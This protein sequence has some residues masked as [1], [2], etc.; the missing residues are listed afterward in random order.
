MQ[1]TTTD[2]NFSGKEIVFFLFLYF[3]LLIS[4]FLGE[5]STGGA[6]LD[7]INQKK[8]STAFVDDFESTLLNYGNF[9]TRHSPIFIIFLSIFEKFRLSDEFIRIIHLHMCL[10]FPL[11][12]YQTLKIKFPNLNYKIFIFLTGLIFLSPTFRTLAIWPDSRML[13]L[14]FFIISVFFFL[15]FHEDKKFL[16]VI[17]NIFFYTISS[18][19][20]PNFSVFS[21]FFFVGYFKMFGFLSLKLFIIILLNFLLSFPAIYYIFI[22]KVDF[23]NQGAAIG[24]DPDSNFIFTNIFNS[25]LLTFSILFFYFIP[26]FITKII[27]I[28]NILKI[29]NLISSLIIFLICFFYFDYDYNIS[30]GGIFFK[31]SNFIFNNNLLF[32]CISFIAIVFILP[33]IL[34]N[35]KNFL[36]FFLIIVSSPQY[37]IYHKY[38]DPFFLIAFFILFNL[39]INLHN[40]LLKK[41]VIIIYI[42]FISFLFINNIKFLW[43]I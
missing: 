7:Y 16:Y 30:G 25:I 4:F 37:T 38:F 9:S 35:F 14:T 17:L 24:V 32:Y 36:I 27:S 8:I 19:I 34:E 13:G 6:I 11:F 22:L 20:S 33:I 43:K 15:K 29:K 10:L 18:Y 2:N 5:N 41:H 1:I 39:N 23:I 26:F 28:N 3:T 12:F 21:L 42:Y 31:T 40:I